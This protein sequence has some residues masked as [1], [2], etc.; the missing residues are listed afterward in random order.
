[1]TEYPRSAAD[2]RHIESLEKENTR[3]LS[4]CT[5]ANVPSDVIQIFTAGEVT[6][7]DLKWAKERIQLH[8]EQESAKKLT[9]VEVIDHTERDPNKIGRVYVNQN[10]KNKVELSFQDNDRTLKIFISNKK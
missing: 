9:R 5:L 2:E 10:D 6:E 4:I 3:L 1:M 8:R 7:K